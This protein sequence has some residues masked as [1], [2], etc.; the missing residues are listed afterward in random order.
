MLMKRSINTG[1]SFWAK[2]QGTAGAVILMT[3]VVVVVIFI[4]PI[5]GWMVDIVHDA[6][7]LTLYSILL[8]GLISI[9]VFIKK[10]RIFTIYVFQKV[11]EF[12]ANIF[13]D[14]DPIGI[15]KALLRALIIRFKKFAD[16]VKK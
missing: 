11:S 3:V 13:T 8:A 5:L 6:L 15:L 10:S 7:K 1:E 9:L 12:F 2:P 14:I 16:G 4:R